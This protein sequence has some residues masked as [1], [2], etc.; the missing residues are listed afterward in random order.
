MTTR[1]RKHTFS[2]LLPAAALLVGLLFVPPATATEI[3]AENTGKGCVFCHQESTGG[4]LK[5]VGFAYVKNAY[6]YPIPERIL[7]KAESL[8]TPFH[9]TVRF[10]VGYFHLLAAVIFFGAIF[11]IHIFIRP[12]RLKGGI[13][14]YE[15]VLGVSCMG[16]LALTGAYLT[17]VRIDTWGQFFNNTFGLM[18]FVKIVLF[19]LMVAIGI[20][21]I[22]IIHRRM[23][24][25]VAPVKASPSTDEMPFS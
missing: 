15:R 17:Y 24:K 23:G 18:L 20:T 1:L 10:I 6:Q 3:Y 21:A 2:F 13:P 12:S 22:T 11:Y 7:K 9:K 14:K 4:P 8:Q 5:A 19:L 16:T 25:E